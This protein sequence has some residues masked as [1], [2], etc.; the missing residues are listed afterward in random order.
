MGRCLRGRCMREEGGKRCRVRCVKQIC[1][2]YSHPYLHSRNIRIV[3]ISSFAS[4]HVEDKSS[5]SNLNPHFEL[6]YYPHLHPYSREEE[7]ADVQLSTT[8]RAI[9]IKNIRLFPYVIMH[10]NY[11]SE[12]SVR[13]QCTVC[14]RT[15]MGSPCFTGPQAQ[16]RRTIGNGNLITDYSFCQLL[17]Y[18]SSFCLP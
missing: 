10:G 11:Q 2:K 1:I 4:P 13:V 3:F 12:R 6:N 17:F 8:C 9:I 14:T 5:A 16:Q 15:A 18:E 7:V